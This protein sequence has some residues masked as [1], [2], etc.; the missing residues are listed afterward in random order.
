MGLA[1][2]DLLAERVDV[3]EP[4]L[5]RRTDEDRG[6]AG[7]PIGIVGDFERDMNRMAAA[8]ANERALRRG[9]VLSDG[10]LEPFLTRPICSVLALVTLFTMLM[11]IPAVNRRV[12]D[13]WRSFKSL[14]ARRPG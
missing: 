11:Y 2:L 14:F 1:R 5:E 6:G 4:P 7:R 3:T 13:A 12:S 8:E 9:L 10:S